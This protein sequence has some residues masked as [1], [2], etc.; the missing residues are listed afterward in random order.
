MGDIYRLGIISDTHLSDLSIAIELAS[1]LING[2]F[3]R[4]D[5]ILHAG[6]IVNAD[7]ES[8]F[9]EIPIYAVQGNMDSARLGLPLRRIIKI[10]NFRVG[11]IHGW[12]PPSAVPRNVLSEFKNDNL[13]LLVFGHSHT[14]FHAHVGRT[15]LF[16]PGSATDHRGNADRCSV[17]L[18]EIGQ[19]ISAKHIS[20][21]MR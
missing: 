18:V 7:F 1:Q 12:G 10:A 11:L 15:L 8:C 6:D 5:A 16:N 14:P 3:A 9:D 20:F 4:V 21:E 17:G 13:D 19:M 2:P